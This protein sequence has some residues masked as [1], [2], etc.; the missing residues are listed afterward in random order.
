MS[1]LGE[2]AELANELIMDAHS[3]GEEKKPDWH[4]WV[5]ISTL[6]LAL[7]TAISALLAGVTAQEALIG[8][9]EEII[10]VSI[11]DTDL[12]L[13]E[14]LRAKHDILLTFGETPDAEEVSRIAAY[15]EEVA[16]LEEEIAEEEA[17]VTR[18]NSAHLIFAIAA[19]VLT[20]GIA[21]AG[22]AIVVNQRMLWIGGM[23]FG[24]AGI[25]VLVFG[26]FRFF[27]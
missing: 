14:V 24:A 26:L 1:E 22:M 5:G 15:E 3:E 16:Q 10:E 12:I 8:R 11:E 13:I 17:T 21:V 9:T 2:Q 27:S 4:R 18:V 25:A 20:V 6:G 19:T 23:S 7:F